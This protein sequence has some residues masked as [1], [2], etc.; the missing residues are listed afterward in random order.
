MDLKTTTQEEIFKKAKDKLWDIKAAYALDCEKIKKWLEEN[1]R[2]ELSG[3]IIGMSG[4]QMRD[5]AIAKYDALS[6]DLERLYNVHELSVDPKVMQHAK[7]GVFEQKAPS[8]S[9]VW[10]FWFLVLFMTG[11]LE[12]TF[13]GYFVF[14]KGAGPALIGLAVLLL[15][16]G[17]LAGHGAA[18]IMMHGKEA[19]YTASENKIE[20]KHIILLVIGIVLIALVIG[21]R[22]V[23]GGF[24]AGI[25]AALFGLAVT[26]AEAFFTYNKAA[27]KFYLK[28][29]FRAQEFYSA[30]QLRR[31]L[32]D[33]STT[34]DDKWRIDYIA[35]IDSTTKTLRDTTAPAGTGS[36]L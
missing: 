32:G 33:S 22:G 21:L 11:G 34:T 31:D 3:A 13:F 1:A 7:D 16:G 6:N 28:L 18:E 5:N 25:V 23:Y 12:L 8:V 19:E 35:Y 29:M 24:L 15:A 20:K 36:V 17:L 26:T 10:F 14:F 9:A 2:V 27:R 30:A 4:K